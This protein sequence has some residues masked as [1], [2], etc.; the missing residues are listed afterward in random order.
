MVNFS[1][2]AMLT[3]TATLVSVVLSLGKELD[4]EPW[5]TIFSILAVTAAL[6]SKGFSRAES[7]TAFTLLIGTSVFL[8]ASLLLA[9]GIGKVFRVSTLAFLAAIVTFFSIWLFA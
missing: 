5:V 4:W 1:V 2:I 8:S 9:N 6:F 7:I 3:L